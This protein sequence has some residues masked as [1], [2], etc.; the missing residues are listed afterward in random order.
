M[1]ILG[2]PITLYFM[3][4]SGNSPLSMT[5]AFISS[6]S[7]ANLCAT[8]AAAGQWGQVKLTKTWI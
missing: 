1:M 4:K 2:T 8:A 5:S 6:H 3:D 7:T